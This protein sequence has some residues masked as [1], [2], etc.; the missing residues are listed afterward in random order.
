MCACEC[1]G[2]NVRVGAWVGFS[3]WVRGGR[4]GGGVDCNNCTRGHEGAW[5][6]V[7]VEIWDSTLDGAFS[8]G[9][10]YMDSA[11]AV[12]VAIMV[13]VGNCICATTATSSPGRGRVCGFS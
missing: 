11:Q 12:T 7:G 8:I 5:G 2:G 9:F 13:I 3:E 4:L 10:S 1:V 6:C